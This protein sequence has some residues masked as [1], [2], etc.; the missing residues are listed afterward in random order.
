MAENDLDSG[1]ASGTTG[2][3]TPETSAGQSHDNS[4]N[5]AQLQ[6]AIDQLTKRLDEVDTRARTVQGEK[7]KTLKKTS[8]EVN[9]L[10]RKIAEIEKLKKSGLPEDAAIEEFSFREEVRALREQLGRINPA[11]PQPAGN[12]AGLAVETAKVL[13]QY[14]LDGNDAEVVEKVIKAGSPLEAENAALKIA[15]RRTQAPPPSPASAPTLTGKAVTNED[16]QA[17][18]DRLAKLQKE[19]TK[20]GAEIKKLSEELGW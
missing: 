1:V 20:H 14:Q 3:P 16:V 9:E 15:Y 11:Q 19:P 10:K 13:E 2:T 5:A 4:I 7:D 8:D 6:T 12:G 18:I 17:K